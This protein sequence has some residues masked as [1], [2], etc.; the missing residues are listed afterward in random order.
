MTDKYK[1]ASAAPNGSRRADDKAVL[2]P[3]AT[4]AEREARL[5]GVVRGATR[6]L[7][8]LLAGANAG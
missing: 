2:A 7:G 4:V 5:L 6:D 3:E 8:A 1:P